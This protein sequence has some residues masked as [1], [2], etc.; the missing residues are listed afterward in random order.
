L[1]TANCTNC[2]SDELYATEA[3]TPAGGL[4]GPNLLPNL[5]TG[6]FM[7]V[8]CGECGLTRLFARRI[9]VQA[10][11]ARGWVKVSEPVRPL[12]LSEDH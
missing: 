12:G 8:V 2:G 6:R 7:V 4:F 9:D 5:P 11:W 1:S 10:L 3:P